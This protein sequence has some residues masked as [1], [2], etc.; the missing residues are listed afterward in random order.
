[1][2]LALWGAR[3]FPEGLSK[4]MVA[5]TTAAASP[6]SP[7]AV[8]AALE[9][10]SIALDTPG[11]DAASVSRLADALVNASLAAAVATALGAASTA[12]L[13]SNLLLDTYFASLGVHCDALASSGRLFAPLILNTVGVQCTLPDNSTFS[14][15]PTSAACVACLAIAADPGA[16]VPTLRSAVQWLNATVASGVG[17]LH[18]VNTTTPL[19]F[20]FP[21]TAPSSTCLVPGSP[22]T[23]CATLPSA[24]P[25]GHSVALNLTDPSSPSWSLSGPLTAGCTRILLNCTA[26]DDYLYAFLRESQ[27]YPPRVYLSPGHPFDFPT[28]QCG[29]S[30]SG[31]NSLGSSSQA[32]VFFGDDC[33]L[34]QAGNPYN[35]SFDAGTQAFVGTGCVPSPVSCA[36]AALPVAWVPVNSGA[37]VMT[38]LTADE[39]GFPAL[40]VQLTRG[41]LYSV[42]IAVCA[43]IVGTYLLASGISIYTSKRGVSGLQTHQMGFL[44]TKD[45]A[46]LWALHLHAADDPDAFS[47]RFVVKPRLGRPGGSAVAVA[48]AIGLPLVR[49]RSALPDVLWPPHARGASGV[50]VA[51]G[52]PAGMSKAALRATEKEHRLARASMLAI[53]GLFSRWRSVAPQPHSASEAPASSSSMDSESTDMQLEDMFTGTALMYAHIAIT[54]L[55]PLDQLLL[56]EAASARALAKLGMRRLGRWTLRS[57]RGAFY[58]MLSSDSSLRSPDGPAWVEAARVWSLVLSQRRDGAWAPD[59][60]FAAALSARHVGGPEDEERGE[61]DD[62]TS[63]LDVLRTKEQPKTWPCPLTFSPLALLE[64]AP[65]GLKRKHALQLQGNGGMPPRGRHRDHRDRRQIPSSAAAPS[66]DDEDDGRT[67]DSSAS[68]QPGAAGVADSRALC[69]WC[70]LLAVERLAQCDEMPIFED[71]STVVDRAAAYLKRKNF[72]PA[73]T[74]WNFAVRQALDSWAKAEE[75]AQDA[76]LG[77]KH[78]AGARGQRW[79]TTAVVTLV[80]CARTHHDTFSAFL[81]PGGTQMTRVQRGAIAV[82]AFIAPLAGL[83]LLQGYRGQVCCT[84]LRT[85]LTCPSNPD[86]PCRGIAGITCSQLAVVLASVQDTGLAGYACTRFPDPNSASQQTGAASLVAAFASVVTWLV[87][88]AIV[89]TNRRAA[90]AASGGVQVAERPPWYAL[91]F[92]RL[93][94][95]DRGA[96]IRDWRWR[97]VREAGSKVEN[98]V[99]DASLKEPL[100]ERAVLLLTRLAAEPV[101]VV[102]RLWRCR[103]SREEYA[104]VTQVE[105]NIPAFPLIVGVWALLVFTL[106]IGLDDMLWYL[107]DSPLSTF[108]PS[109]AVAYAVD[110]VCAALCCV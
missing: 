40:P 4:F 27:A 92:T 42:A 99:V 69:T 39:A 52:R 94:A 41:F 96:R 48:S 10:L 19:V 72:H 110:Q 100:I 83:A 5:A 107:G 60:S 67:N 7:P 38:V 105:A 87:R 24:V 93:A 95:P 62:A 77:S 12:S 89:T 80:Q 53:R 58:A 35:C 2:L 97:A 59:A 98:A 16:G 33:Q 22:S 20:T 14:R 30:S 18:E 44:V 49:L 6:L 8:E 85:A 71:G 88:T 1:M 50:A 103:L 61:E 25:P 78:V 28:T 65:P 82:T 73:P 31:G 47:P 109:A 64:A 75:E 101:R 90:D 21:P 36:C 11:A 17:P 26:G 45:G 3:T 9:L 74:A 13:A 57:L 55:M 29:T 37:G 76:A 102:H 15:A 46:W 86:L 91:L 81:A 63:C 23:P 104:I 108:I 68:I 79:W 66:D 32:Q 84:D 70:T 54:M 51:V 56:H 34:W 43:S 106:L